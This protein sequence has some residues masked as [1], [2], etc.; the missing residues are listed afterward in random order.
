MMVNYKIVEF[1]AAIMQRLTDNLFSKKI[2]QKEVRQSRLYFGF[3]FSKRKGFWV[4]ELSQY[5]PNISL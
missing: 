1:I 5:F 4:L 3:L 2:K